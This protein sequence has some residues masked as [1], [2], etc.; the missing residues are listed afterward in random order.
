MES[1]LRGVGDD[2]ACVYDAARNDA[3]RAQSE[4]ERAVSAFNSKVRGY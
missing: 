1:Y 3:A 4:A 2:I